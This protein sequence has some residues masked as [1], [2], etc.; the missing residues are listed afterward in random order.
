MKD[1]E[2]RALEYAMIKHKGIYRKGTTHE[3]YINHPLRVAELIKKYK[4]DSKG[5]EYLTSAAYLHDVLEDTNTTFEELVDKFGIQVAELVKE[6]TSIKE[7]K[8]AM[9]KRKYLAVKLKNMSNWALTLKLCDRLDNISDLETTNEK[10]RLKYIDET[11][12]IIFYLMNNREL[13]ET[14]KNIVAD[15]TLT[16]QNYTNL[17]LDKPKQKTISLAS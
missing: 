12:Y 8:N 17:G 4:G 11:R 14:Q 7:M 1:I 10:F 3:P 6:V 15:I 2:K 5:I 13:T 9:G 16:L